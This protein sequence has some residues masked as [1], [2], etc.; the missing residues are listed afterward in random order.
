VAIVEPV[1]VFQFPSISSEWLLCAAAVLRKNPEIIGSQWVG[2]SFCDFAY[3]GVG[4][5][6]VQ[7]IVATLLF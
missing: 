2:K 1:S 7:P 5:L 3:A 6:T 4:E